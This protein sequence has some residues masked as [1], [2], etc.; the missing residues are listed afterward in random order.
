MVDWVSKYEPSYG[1]EEPLYKVSLGA[2]PVGKSKSPGTA[3]WIV[4]GEHYEGGCKQ[5]AYTKPGAACVAP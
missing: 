4:A 3:K 5:L 1:P 2:A